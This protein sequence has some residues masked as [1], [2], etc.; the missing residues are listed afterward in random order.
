MGRGDYQSCQFTHKKGSGL[1]AHMHVYTWKEKI[2]F[3]SFYDFPCLDSFAPQKNGG[4]SLIEH[5]RKCI[6]THGHMTV[7]EF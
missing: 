5:T 1:R 6:K 7:F 4:C 3:D 2:Y